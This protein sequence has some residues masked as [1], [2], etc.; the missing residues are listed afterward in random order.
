ME[1][2]DQASGDGDRIIVGVDGSASSKEALKWAVRQA[3]LTG[4]RVLAVAAWEIPTSFGWVPPYPSDYDPAEDAKSMLESTVG[5]VLG[6]DPDVDFSTLV[7]E[8]KASPVLTELS[9]SASLVVVGSR[10]H[11]EFAGMLLGSVSEWLTAH[12]HCPVLVVRH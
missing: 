4:T 12:A 6:P 2:Q 7:L 3:R 5:E 8:G 11:G 9:R 10:G 1:S